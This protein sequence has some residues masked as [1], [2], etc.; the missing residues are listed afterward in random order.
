MN[1]SLKQ[2]LQQDYR[3]IKAKIKEILNGLGVRQE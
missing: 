2:D 1:L 3:R